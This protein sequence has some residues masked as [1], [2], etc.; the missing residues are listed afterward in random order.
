MYVC[1][2]V[3]ACVHVSVVITLKKNDSPS[4]ALSAVR[5]SLAG[6]FLTSMLTLS[7]SGHKS[8]WLKGAKGIHQNDHPMGREKVFI[9]GT[10]ENGQRHLGKCAMLSLQDREW[11][12]EEQ[13]I[14]AGALGAEKIPKIQRKSPASCKGLCCCS[15]RRAGF[16]EPRTW[17]LVWGADLLE[18]V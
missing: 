10:R 3:Y 15:R 7:C 16:L 6:E 18:S 11:Q 8:K 9:V 2:Y 4:S 1:M 5:S 14:S 13:T 12:G 17:K